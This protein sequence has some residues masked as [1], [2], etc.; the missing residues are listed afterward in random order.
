MFIKKADGSLR[1]VV[2]YQKLNEVTVKDVYPLPRQDNLMAKLR[3][4][5]IFIKLDLQWGYNNIRIKE[6]NKWKTVF[7]T[8]YGS[9]EYLVMLFG[10]T[11]APA[12]FQQFMNN[13]FRDLLDISV[14]VYLNNIL[15]FSKDPAEHSKHVRE[16]LH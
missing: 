16:V 4:A 11:N 1:L 7:K 15:I 12:A 2:D 14:V 6:G 10:L 13:L 5:K 8:K 3:K 9:F